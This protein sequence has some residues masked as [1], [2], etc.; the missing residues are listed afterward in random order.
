MFQSLLPVFFCAIPGY[1]LGK[2]FDISQFGTYIWLALFALLNVFLIRM[3]AIRLGAA[4]LAASL[5]GIAF[6]LQH[7]LLRML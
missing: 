5:A 1:I 4:P 3:I 6:F 7:R 2:Y